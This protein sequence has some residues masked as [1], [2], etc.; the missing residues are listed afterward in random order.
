MTHFLDG[1]AVYGADIKTQFEVRSFQG[2]R[3]RMLNEFGHSLLP[4]SAEKG[5]C[6]S[7]D[8]GPCFFAGDG[9]ANQIISLVAVQTLF[10][11]EHNRIAD[12]LASL[13]PRWSDDVIFAETQRV[14]IAELQHI[15]YKEWVPEAVGSETMDRFSLHVHE[16]GYSNDYNPEV[17]PSVTSEF[18]TAAQRFGHSTVDGKFLYVFYYSINLLDFFIHFLRNF[19][20]FFTGFKRELKL[21]K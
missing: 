7:L 14:V 9:R 12:I 20:L 21:M 16:D 13:N 18:S 10:A 2:G 8:H 5:D 19:I 1:S 17:N 4:L 15:I 11:R 3:L 6:G